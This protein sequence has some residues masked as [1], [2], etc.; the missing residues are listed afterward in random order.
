[1]EPRK[2]GRTHVEL[3][4]GCGGMALGL[5][6]AGFELLL[7]NEL[8]PMAAETFA[9]NLLGVDLSGPA[10]TRLSGQ[11]NRGGRELV[12]WL[13]SRHGPEALA[14]RLRENPHDAPVRLDELDEPAESL[15]GS[16]VIGSVIDLKHWLNGE[17]PKGAEA[18]RSRQRGHEFAVW[19]RE[20][21]I[22]L[23]SGG[24]PCQSFSLAGLR[25]RLNPRNRLPFEFA[26][27][28][29]LLQPG[30]V[31]LENVS[32][33]L[34][35][36]TDPATGQQSVPAL[37]VA[38]AFAQRGFLPLCFHL[39]AWHFGVAQNRPRFVMMG[40]NLAKLF[41]PKHQSDGAGDSWIS[42]VQR[43]ARRA[44]RCASEEVGHNTWA[45]IRKAAGFYLEVHSGDRC[46]HWKRR[47]EGLLAVNHPTRPGRCGGFPGS[48]SE[49][50]PIASFVWESGPDCGKRSVK[51]AIGDLSKGEAFA[52]D[53]LEMLPGWAR[54]V[55]S[56]LLGKQ[57]PNHEHRRN[58]D[59]VR[60][61]FRLYQ[62]IQN[63][64][65]SDRDRALFEAA[66][67]DRDE[68][69][70]REAGY[71]ISQEGIEAVARYGVLNLTGESL[72]RDEPGL[73]ERILL[74][75]EQLHTR[76]HSQA[77]LDPDQPA[78]AALSIPDDACHYARG[79]DRTLTVREMARIQSFPDWFEFRSKV[80]TGGTSRR[81]EVPQYTQV[82]N[83]VPPLMAQGLGMVVDA[84][85]RFLGRVRLPTN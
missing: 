12:R 14:N 64:G 51:E 61:R 76:K 81:F 11:K 41:G 79:H 32:G 47:L 4:A 43:L 82:G 46:G 6:A 37:E 58:C 15:R 72:S 49:L 70:R 9:Y 19:L 57:I 84:L 29:R 65:I 22:D 10:T 20:Q 62:A 30:I 26:E 69:K 83:A 75:V 39:N 60:A 34:R 54:N 28:A 55:Q 17:S 80:T 13:N 73:R 8:S 68:E 59:R 40:I 3:F 50:D 38:T 18:S 27:L 45:A 36:F 77:A 2:K 42:L 56:Q 16:L 33:I 52:I 53:R 63:T 67:Q 5:E 44:D 21:G 1:M 71:Q 85:Y 66:L 24:P 48:V 78:P 25:D 31:L 7:A 35:P 74:L 23:M